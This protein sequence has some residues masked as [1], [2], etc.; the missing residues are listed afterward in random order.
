M[1]ASHDGW[2]NAPDHSERSPRRYPC[3]GEMLTLNETAVVMADIDPSAQ[4]EVSGRP[5][6]ADARAGCAGV[7][8]RGYF[9]HRSGGLDAANITPERRLFHSAPAQLIGRTVAAVG[10]AELSCYGFRHRRRR[11]EDEAAAAVKS[12]APFFAL[13]FPRPPQPA[14]EVVRPAA[15]LDAWELLNAFGRHGREAAAGSWSARC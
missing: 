10:A 9:R 5:A 15:E 8:R 12:L 3:A 6:N 7:S 11:G 1:P 2:P 13:A 4:A 14:G